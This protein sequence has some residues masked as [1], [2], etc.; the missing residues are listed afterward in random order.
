MKLIKQLFCIH[1]YEYE[2]NWNGDLIKVCRKFDKV[3]KL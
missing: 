1:R 2:I 3:K